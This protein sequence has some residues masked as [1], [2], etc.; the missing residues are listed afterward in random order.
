MANPLERQDEELSGRSA[1]QTMAA[2]VGIV[3]I[4]FGV[5]L[6]AMLFISVLGYLRDPTDFEKMVARWEMVV[7]ASGSN[8]GP[9]ISLER[10]ERRDSFTTPADAEAGT[11]ATHTVAHQ[12]HEHRVHLPVNATRVT[13]IGIMI[14]LLLVLVRIAIGI[15]T[16]GASLVA[17]A[18]PYKKIHEKMIRDLAMQRTTHS[19]RRPAPPREDSRPSKYSP[20]GR[21]D[22]A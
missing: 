13:T 3:L 19:P 22:I 4:I 1:L 5:V 6:A 8:E 11:E 18:N 7:S 12:V 21:D 10:A 2:F 17:A 9:G 14:V 15:I 20:A 16:A